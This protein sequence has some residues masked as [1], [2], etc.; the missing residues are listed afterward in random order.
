MLNLQSFFA[1][2]TISQALANNGD[3]EIIEVTKEVTKAITM[4]WSCVHFGGQ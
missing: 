4:G 3:E 1:R 2:S